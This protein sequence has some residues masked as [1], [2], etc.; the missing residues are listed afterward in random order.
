ML[1]NIVIPSSRKNG[2]LLIPA[3]RKNEFIR[4]PAVGQLLPT[5]DIR[6]VVSRLLQTSPIQL[7][8]GPS[9]DKYAI[10]IWVQLDDRVE[11]KM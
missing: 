10:Y 6:D 3:F 5:S 9:V 8:S 1:G 11:I 2:L 7:I 4:S